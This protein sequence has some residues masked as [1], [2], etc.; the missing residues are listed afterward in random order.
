MNKS[1]KLNGNETIV[2]WTYKGPA[3][4]FSMPQVAVTWIIEHLCFY[5]ASVEVDSLVLLKRGLR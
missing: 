2:L 1:I 5:S 4:T 3:A